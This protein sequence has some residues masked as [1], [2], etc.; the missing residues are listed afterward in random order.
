MSSFIRQ[1]TRGTFPGRCCWTWSLGGRMPCSTSTLRR[2]SSRPCTTRCLVAHTSLTG[3]SA[4]LWMATALLTFTHCL[5]RQIPPCQIC[6]TSNTAGVCHREQ[7]YAPLSA[8]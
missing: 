4:A 5:G 7:V 2:H 8:L 6:L 3:S 1:M